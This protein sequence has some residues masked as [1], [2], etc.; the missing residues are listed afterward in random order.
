MMPAPGDQHRPPT[1]TTNPFEETKPHVNEY[2]AQE[3]AT[4]QSRLEKQLGPEYISSRPGAAGQKVHYL[5]AEKCIN[6]ANE[7]FGFNGWSSAIQQVQI[8][9]VDES[10][11][12]GKITLGLSVIVRVSLRDG[13]FHEDIGY[14]HIENCKGKA[15]AFEKA[16]KEGT[17]DALKRALRNFG[18]VLGNCIYDKE[19]LAK[20][21]K[22]KIAPS[23]WDI[24]NLHRHP[25]FAPVKKEEEAA[26]LS[27]NGFSNP[28]SHAEAEDEFGGDDFDEVDF[29][30]SHSGLAG[31]PDEVV[32]EPSVSSEQ[33]GNRQRPS[34]GNQTSSLSKPGQQAMQQQRPP[35]IR[36]HSVSGPLPPQNGVLAP[37]VNPSGRPVTHSSNN[38]Q[39]PI[40]TK[41]TSNMPPQSRMAAPNGAITGAQ[42]PQQAMAATTQNVP[43]VQH[44]RQGQPVAVPPQYTANGQQPKG[45]AQP[46]PQSP[47]RQSTNQSEHKDIT[48]P[49]A[50]PL[51]HEPPIGFYTARAAESL[52]NPDGV[53]PDVPVFNPHL[54]SPSIRKTSGVDH[55]KSKPVNRE[56]AGVPPPP[57]LTN[58]N[59]PA[60]LTVTRAN[61][62]NPQ[63]DVSRRIGM[64]GAGASPLQNRTSYKPPQMKRP[65]ESS[66]VPQQQQQPRPPLGDVS[67]NQLTTPSDVGGDIKRP[68]L[69]TS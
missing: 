22:V 44:A 69:S 63:L 1:A 21:T 39:T 50:P 20:V 41:T 9:F 66:G 38:P 28:S 24:E 12:T 3:I 65:A 43:N 31:N 55:T 8:D 32:L 27:L 10:Q 29:S 67:T 23:R 56:L 33:F 25:D 53:P 52:Q 46:A 45:A 62:V 34:R 16:K 26:E 11:A 51:G 54:E 42:R 5:A 40:N 37:Q 68:R 17:T 47:A 30:E 18:N 2:T 13:T 36:G 48:A 19:Y 4:L 35:V 15:A 14:G 57:P 61:F 59:T 64:P 49:P 60:A 6:L 58:L 7:V